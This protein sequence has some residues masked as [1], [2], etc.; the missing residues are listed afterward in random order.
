MKSIRRGRCC[1]ETWSKKWR[2]PLRIKENK[3]IYFTCLKTNR[4]ND[5]FID[6]EKKNLKDKLA[7]FASTT[8]EFEI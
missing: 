1:L 4:L 7:K 5:A 6:K 3:S 2:H 8:E